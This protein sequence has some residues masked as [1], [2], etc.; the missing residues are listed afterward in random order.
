ML[1]I[2][3]NIIG[4]TDIILVKYNPLQSSLINA[5]FG[6]IT[7]ILFIIIGAKYNTNKNFRGCIFGGFLL[8]VLSCFQIVHYFTVGVK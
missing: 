8:V 3:L 4:V 6:I 2:T 1:V 7:G 5:I